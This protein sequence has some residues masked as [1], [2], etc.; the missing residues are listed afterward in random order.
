[1]SFHRDVWF[2]VP[3]YPMMR[4]LYSFVIWLKWLAM[5]GNTNPRSG[6]LSRWYLQ[7][8]FWPHVTCKALQAYFR[9]D[10][11]Q[12]LA[13]GA[14]KQFN[15]HSQ[16]KQP[17]RRIMTCHNSHVPTLSYDL[18]AALCSSLIFL[19]TCAQ[20][21]WVTGDTWQ[22]WYLTWV[23]DQVNDSCC[24]W[25]IRMYH[26]QHVWACCSLQVVNILYDSVFGNCQ[27]NIDT[28][29]LVSFYSP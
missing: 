23:Y 22:T 1:M 9:Y 29:V 3:Q 27:V 10:E 8:F 2:V 24:M 4:L 25:V 12:P 14:R 17:Q 16:V 26:W 5:C 11:I 19:K 13:S 15:D 28:L 18:Y 7:V 20:L 21:G 6:W